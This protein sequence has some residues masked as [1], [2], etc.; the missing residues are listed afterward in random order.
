MVSREEGME[1]VGKTPPKKGMLRGVM[2]TH[3]RLG[4]ILVYHS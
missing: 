4:D 3:S 1:D 2:N